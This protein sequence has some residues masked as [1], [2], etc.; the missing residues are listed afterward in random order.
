[1]SCE[2]CGEDNEALVYSH[3]IPTSYSPQDCFMEHTRMNLCH[4]HAN[5]LV[6]EIS[7]VVKYAKQLAAYEKE[8][9][10]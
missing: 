10:N 7:W 4:Q 6:K 9:K 8:K 2:I 3:D 5:W 1:V